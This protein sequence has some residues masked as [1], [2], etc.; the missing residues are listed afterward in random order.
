MTGSTAF[1]S[2][3]VLLVVLLLLTAAI[4]GTTTARAGV[5][6]SCGLVTAAGHAWIVVA[7]GVPC[8][9]AKR[10]TR[11]LAART[12]GVPSGHHVTVSSPLHGF[13]CVLASRGKPG[14]SCATP[15]AARS[16]LWIVA[17]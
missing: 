12:A 2:R 11:G 17:A 15:G 6:G 3:L 1:R 4:A 16:V 8:S 14:G 5:K 10:V 7:K 9:T 13:H